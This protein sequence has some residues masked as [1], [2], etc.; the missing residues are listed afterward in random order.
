MIDTRDL[1]SYAASMSAEICINQ[2]MEAVA[3][4]TTDQGQPTQCQARA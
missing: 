1:T 4:A 2:P 3:Y